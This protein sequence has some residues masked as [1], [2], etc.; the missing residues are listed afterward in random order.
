MAFGITTPWTPPDDGSGEDS[1]ASTTDL[2]TSAVGR[3]S[4]GPYALSAQAPD[5]GLEEFPLIGPTNAFATQSLIDRSNTLFAKGSA[6]LASNDAPLGGA[7]LTTQ[8]DLGLRG[9]VDV[10]PPVMTASDAGLRGPVDAPKP[11]TPLRVPQVVGVGLTGSLYLGAGGGLTGGV[12]FDSGPK[13]DWHFFL[14]PEWG[15]GLDVGVGPVLVTA[16]SLDAFKGKSE[17]A[18][19]GPVSVS[20]N[21]DGQSY[22][23]SPSAGVTESRSRT[24][25]SPA[26]P[27]PPGPNDYGASFQYGF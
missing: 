10:E 9:P 27:Q 6:V 21:P 23:V 3:A 19:F 7:H 16:D 26:L 4:S 2:L 25:V 24:I 18:H 13:P 11:D 22:A 14:T 5:D 12:V 15:T 8:P 20:T 1:G 17:S